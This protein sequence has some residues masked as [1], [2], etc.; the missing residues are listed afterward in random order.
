MVPSAFA[1]EAEK[2]AAG[3]SANEE[4]S[5]SIDKEASLDRALGDVE[6]P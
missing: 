2:M 3:P 1:T 6:A 5:L 4:V